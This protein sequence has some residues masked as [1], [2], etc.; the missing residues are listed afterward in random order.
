ME[1]SRNVEENDEEDEAEVKAGPSKTRSSETITVSATNL[2]SDLSRT[3][4]VKE[5][6]PRDKG[7][8]DVKE[9]HEDCKHFSMLFSLCKEICVRAHTKMFVNQ[10]ID[11]H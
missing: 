9:E 2:A 1:E 5:A 7:S 3:G 8:Q 11:F 6:R 4:S 10:L